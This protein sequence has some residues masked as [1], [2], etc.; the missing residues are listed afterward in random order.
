MRFDLAKAH[1]YPRTVTSKLVIRL[2]P[3]LL[4]DCAGYSLDNESYDSQGTYVEGIVPI[5][6]V[7]RYLAAGLRC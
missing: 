4:R 2:R 1:Q 7:A 6:I 3:R 5:G